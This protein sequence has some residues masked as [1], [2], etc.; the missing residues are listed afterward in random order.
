MQAAEAQEIL[1]PLMLH[2][3]VSRRDQDKVF[4]RP[5]EGL[6][7]VVLSTNMAETSATRLAYKVHTHCIAITSR[8][9]CDH[10]DF[11]SEESTSLSTQTRDQDARLCAQ[12]FGALMSA[13]EAGLSDPSVVVAGKAR[14]ARNTCSEPCSLCR[15]H[16]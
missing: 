6:V 9:M 3:T 1:Y 5:P 8:Q 7:K 15:A 2:S 12:V 13:L 11:L 4:Q 16:S 10:P 14:L